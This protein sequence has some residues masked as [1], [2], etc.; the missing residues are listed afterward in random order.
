LDLSTSRFSAI[1]GVIARRRSRQH[2]VD[3]RLDQLFVAHLVDVI[4][5]HALEDVAEQ[6]Q[7]LVRID[8][9][10]RFRLSGRA[11]SNTTAVTSMRFLSPLGR[12]A[13]ISDWTDGRFAATS[14]R[15]SA[16]CS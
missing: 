5:A 11:I 4:G 1:H 13:G 9:R 3:R 12:R 6:V 8:F 7:Q 10:F 14:G 15:A 2:V 16:S